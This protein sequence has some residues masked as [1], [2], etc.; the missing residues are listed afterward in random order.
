MYF[1]L[2]AM[3]SPCIELIEAQNI[4]TNTINTAIKRI[5]KFL[6]NLRAENI[7]INITPPKIPKGAALAV[8]VITPQKFTAVN[9]KTTT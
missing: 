2:L 6:S 4:G 7:I 9:N 8:E 1:V 3:T 5:I